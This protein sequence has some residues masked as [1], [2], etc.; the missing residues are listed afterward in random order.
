MTSTE[1]EQTASNRDVSGL[2]DKGLVQFALGN[3][4]AAISF[5]KEAEELDPGNDRAQDYLQ[6][7]GAI[8]SLA[9][10]TTDV[11]DEPAT[12]VMPAVTDD[13]VEAVAQQS[14]PDALAPPFSQKVDFDDD[15]EPGDSDEL[16]VEPVV[17]DVE[18]SL[19]DA[20]AAEAAGRLEEALKSADKALKRDPEREETQELVA[21]LRARL[22]AEYLAELEPL[23]R[24]PVLRATDASILELSLDPI[25][26][27]LISQ[28]DGEITIEE[29]LTILGTFDQFRVLSSLHYFLQAGI[30]EL[31]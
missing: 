27:F 3:R 22:S 14:D 26:G 5:W 10:L 20:R 11:P 9:T 8:P 25:G 19:R 23:D 30:I 13:H 17:P 16:T 31:R 6:S 4:E 29:L 21:S 24:V 2:L 1:H 7:V 18:I 15:P 28:I 12:E